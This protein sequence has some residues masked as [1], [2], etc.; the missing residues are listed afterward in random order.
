MMVLL[1]WVHSWN[2]VVVVAD[3]WVPCLP[4]QYGKVPCAWNNPPHF[5]DDDIDLVD[6]LVVVWA[7]AISLLWTFPCENRRILDCRKAVILVALAA[8]MP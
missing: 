1:P 8:T 5:H 4:L 3:A 6:V 2:C 7:C